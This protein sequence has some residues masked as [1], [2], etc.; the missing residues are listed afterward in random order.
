MLTGQS[1]FLTFSESSQ[2][3][4]NESYPLKNCKTIKTKVGIERIISQFKISTEI[5]KVQNFPKRESQSNLVEKQLDMAVQLI[6]CGRNICFYGFGSKDFDIFRV[7]EE[8]ENTHHVFFVRGYYN[9]FLP[10]SMY[11]KLIEFARELNP[12]ARKS[13]KFDGQGDAEELSL[14]LY[15]LLGTIPDSQF[16]L[17]L[18]GLDGPNFLRPSI[19]AGFARLAQLSNFRLLASID[20]S[21]LSFYL[22]RTASDQFNFIYLPFSTLKPYSHELFYLD[23]N[24]NTNASKKDQATVGKFLSSLTVN[25]SELVIFVIKELLKT[26]KRQMEEQELFAKAVSEAKVTSFNQFHEN[27]KEATQH[28]ILEL[29]SMDKCS[30]V[31]KTL[32]EQHE[33]DEII[34]FDSGDEQKSYEGVNS[35]SDD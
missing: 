19:L 31:Y 6:R 30:R 17:I 25:Q 27:L 7:V 29:K 28:K 8:L 18:C 10:R 11:V 12:K 26:D 14:E 3:K 22:S 4:R 1:N 35:E 24:V 9:D 2:L 20:S 13:K 16:C 5:Q 15:N 21:A 23:S 34:E 32:Y 33:L